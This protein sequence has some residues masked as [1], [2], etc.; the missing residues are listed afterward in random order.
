[1]KKVFKNSLEFM[2]ERENETDFHLLVSF[3]HAQ[4]S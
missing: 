4:Y 1:M 3:P 2:Q